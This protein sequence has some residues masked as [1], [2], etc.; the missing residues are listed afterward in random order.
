MQPALRWRGATTRE[1]RMN[2]NPIRGLRAALL[3]LGVLCGSGGAIAQTAVTD[4][5]AGPGNGVYSF[6][7]WTPKTLP[8]L[9]RGQGS[10]ESQNVTGHLFLPPGDAKVPA[11]LLVHGSGGIYSAMLEFWPKALNAA[12]IAVFSMDSFNPR[13][14]KSTAEDQSQVPFAADTADAFAALKLLAT[15]PRI[16]PQRIA[17]MGF[18]RGGITVQRSA[19][20]RIIASQKLPDGLRFAAHIPVYSGGCVGVFRLRVKPGVFSKAPQLWIHG[21][22][23]DYAGMPPCETYAKQI[24]EAGTPV[25]FVVLEGAAHKFDADDPRKVFIRGAQRTLDTCPVELDIDTFAS[26]DRNTGQRLQGEA[27][28]AVL[29][30]CSA[31]GASVEGSTKARDRAAQVTLAFLAKAFAK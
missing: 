8:D 13:G 22:A 10:A 5:K 14:V 18:S 25:E 31:T 2:Y 11:V 26:F 1:R 29:K 23:D 6:A 17:I 19:V 4:F 16:D 15:H 21:N 28:Q 27:Y 30:S 12:G 9:M 24:A 20:E 3:A 7:S